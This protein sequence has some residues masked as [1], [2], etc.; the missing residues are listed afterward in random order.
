MLCHIFLNKKKIKLLL[1]IIIFSIFTF[2]AN[3]KSEDYSDFIE[4]EMEVLKDGKIIGFSNYKFIYLNNKLMVKNQTKFEV[5][6]AGIKIFSIFS[7]SSEEYINNS[8]VSFNSLT[9]QNNKKKYVNLKLDK[10]KSEF[11]I[12]GSS[13]KG[14]AKISNIIGI[15]W[16]KDIL[17]TDSQIS[18]LSGSVKKQL[19]TYLGKENI[20]INNTL[21]V[22]EKYKLVSK[23]PNVAENKKLNFIIWYDR[24]KNLIVKVSYNRLGNWLYRVKKFS[25]KN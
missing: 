25:K 21:Y 13:Y 7:K 18:P 24:K 15:W 19:V 16:N 2:K 5:R 14:K 3:S 9:L 20:T 22:T 10:N 12:D 11:I 6:L 23:E 1:I 8:L 4:I 17:K